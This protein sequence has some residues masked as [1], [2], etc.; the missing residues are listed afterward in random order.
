MFVLS[1]PLN[2]HSSCNWVR[3]FNYLTVLRRCSLRLKI[4]TIRPILLANRW[5][6]YA[7]EDQL[8]IY[9][10]KEDEYLSSS[11]M[12]YSRR[13]YDRPSLQC[14]YTATVHVKVHESWSKSRLCIWTSPTGFKTLIP[15]FPTLGLQQTSG[16]IP[17]ITITYRMKSDSI[18][19]LRDLSRRS[20]CI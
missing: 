1:L 19:H 3:F 11:K 16:Q 13:L 12:I 6:I 7:R 8:C 9:D 14:W 4:S 2:L 20:S 18:V 10:T 15:T 5:I 17:I